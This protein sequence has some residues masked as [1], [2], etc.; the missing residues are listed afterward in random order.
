MPLRGICLED[1]RTVSAASF[2][3]ANLIFIMDHR[4]GCAHL[5]A[6]LLT[7]HEGLML[8]RIMII[9]HNANCM[10]GWSVFFMQGRFSSTYCKMSGST[11]R[12]T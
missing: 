11:R 4:K 2:V 12:W 1:P 10:S 9:S 8:M 3:H 7:R 5:L 6:P